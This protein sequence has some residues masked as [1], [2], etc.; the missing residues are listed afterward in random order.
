VR[1]SIERT[2]KT[3]CNDYD[4][5]KTSSGAHAAS[6]ESEQLPQVPPKVYILRLLLKNLPDVTEKSDHCE[7]YFNLI[8]HLMKQCASN[9]KLEGTESSPK[10]PIN[11][12]RK[13]FLID[14]QTFSALSLLQWCIHQLNS[15]PTYE[16]RFST[17]TDRILGGYL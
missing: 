3:I 12:T 17:Y 10:I 1:R 11:Y 6:S 7:E 8:T 9:F 5:A 13:Q 16:D 4:S 2:F 14:D 15:R